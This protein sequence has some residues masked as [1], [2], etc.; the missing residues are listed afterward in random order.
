[1][2]KSLSSEQSIACPEF[3]LFKQRSARIFHTLNVCATVCSASFSS[4]SSMIINSGGGIIISSS[5]LSWDAMIECEG[6][7]YILTES[8]RGKH[9][10]GGT[11]RRVVARQ[12]SRRYNFVLKMNDISST[13]SA[14]RVYVCVPPPPHSLVSTEA[15]QPRPQLYVIY[16]GDGKV[17]SGH[18]LDKSI[19]Y[20]QQK[21]ASLL[22]PTE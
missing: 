20:W 17:L 10:G 1:M 22:P 21:V 5:P 13:H 2:R 12:L 6:D 8:A 14:P 11:L 3:I 19:Q 16:I 7:V 18:K 4:R 9:A 15:R